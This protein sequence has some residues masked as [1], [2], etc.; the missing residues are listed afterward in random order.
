MPAATHATESDLHIPF[1]DLEAEAGAL[2]EMLLDNKDLGKIALSLRPEAF[3]R[4]A[5]RHIY[6]AIVHL[7]KKGKVVDAVVLRE[8]LQRRGI[9]KSVGGPEAIVSLLDRVPTPG[10]VTHQGG[11]MGYAL[12]VRQVE[13]QRRSIERQIVEAEKSIRGW[14]QDIHSL[15]KMLVALKSMTEGGPPAGAGRPTRRDRRGTWKPGSRGRKPKW[16]LEQQAAKM[17]KK[18]AKKAAKA[19]P[20]KRKKKVSAKQLAGLARAR[21]VLAEKRKAAG[22]STRAG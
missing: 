14:S 1:Q 22:K 3:S 18:P 20:A 19:K 7:H 16:Y 2:G 21:A 4:K 12:I 8:E 11:S 6:E 5:H 9:L 17:A 15:D 10:H 13:S